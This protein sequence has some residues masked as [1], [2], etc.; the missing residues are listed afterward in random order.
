MGRV[1]IDFGG[2]PAEKATLLKV[3]GNIFTLGMV[4]TISES[5]VV[6]EK[7][8]DAL[9]QFPRDDASGSV[10]RVLGSNEARGLLQERRAVI[11]S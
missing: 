10:C 8:V 4:E 7:T 9:H 3:I 1:N 11:R 6:A 5:Y 2:Q